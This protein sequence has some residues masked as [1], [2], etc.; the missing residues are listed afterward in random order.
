MTAI[1]KPLEALRE[2]VSE[3]REFAKS[4]WPPEP[5]ASGFEWHN[6]VYS[7]DEIKLLNKHSDQL[8]APLPALEQQMNAAVAAALERAALVCDARAEMYDKYACDCHGYRR[9]SEHDAEEI[10]ALVSS[11]ECDALETLL[12]EARLAEAKWWKNHVGHNDNHRAGNLC[13]VCERIAELS[14][15]G[16]NDGK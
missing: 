14:A 5:T 11:S 10:R 8:A 12:R 4:T 7:E 15:K 13:W 2:L 1:N 6:P 3:W 9:A 16:E